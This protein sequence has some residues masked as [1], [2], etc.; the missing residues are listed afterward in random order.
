M[1]LWHLEPVTCYLLQVTFD[2]SPIP[3]QLSTRLL[4][5]V[6][7]HHSPVSSKLSFVTYHMSYVTCHLL[8]VTYQLSHFTWHL[9]PVTCYL[10]YQF[11]HCYLESQL[12]QHSAVCS[13]KCYMRSMQYTYVVCSVQ[14]S[15][16]SMKCTGAGVGSD[17]DAG[18]ACGVQCAVQSVRP[19]TG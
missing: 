9:S 8:P 16:Y 6:T 18:A 5:T 13:V 4:S 7:C 11:C 10:F 12:S 17:E 14:C 19:V 15:M 2:L 1:A 3:C